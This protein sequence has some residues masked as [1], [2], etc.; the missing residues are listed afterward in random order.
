MPYA[1]F[2]DQCHVLHKPAQADLQRMATE[3]TLPGLILFGYPFQSLEALAGFARLEVLKI[4]GAPK[5]GTLKGVECL[6]SVREFVL[7]TT[8]GSDGSGECIEVESF[9]P[10]ERVMGLTRLVL[11]GVRPHDLDLSPIMR[12]HRLEELEV[13]GVPE[14]TMEHYAR[15]A[16]ALPGTAGRCLQPF[17]EIPGV[18]ICRKCQKRQVL[19]NGAP[20]KARKWVCPQCNA[21]LLAA[22]VM[23][24]ETLTGKS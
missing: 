14:F 5:L 4:Q 12:M 15:L 3:A 10:L 22:H 8:P 7:S 16:V 9:A 2:D 13:S 18:G 17:V 23:R 19:L 20:P 1:A 6:K 11:L 24:W 21:K